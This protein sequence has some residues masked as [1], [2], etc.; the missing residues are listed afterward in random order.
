MVDRKP[1]NPLKN[2]FDLE[3]CFFNIQ[4]KIFLSKKILN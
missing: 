3:M 1:E 4:K 2:Y